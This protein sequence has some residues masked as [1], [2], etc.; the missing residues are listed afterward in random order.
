MHF[1]ESLCLFVMMCLYVQ[2]M[3]GIE[4]VMNFNMRRFEEKINGRISLEKN[5]VMLT[6]KKRHLTYNE[7]NLIGNGYVSSRL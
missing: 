2:F 4:R 3:E 6:L 7:T 5:I 1:P